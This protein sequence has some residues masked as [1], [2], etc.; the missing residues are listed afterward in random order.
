[1]VSRG[2]WVAA[3][4]IAKLELSLEVG[5]PEVIRGSAFRER[6]AARWRDSPPRLT[7]S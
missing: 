1:M 4:P 3:L 5:A 2:Q 6:R 7:R